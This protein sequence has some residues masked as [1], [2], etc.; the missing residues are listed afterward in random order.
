MATD[1]NRNTRHLNRYLSLAAGVS[2]R[3]ADEMVRNGRV[4]LDGLPVLDPGT[5][6]DPSA[7]EVRLDGRTLVPV[8][9]EDRLD[10]ALPGLSP[11]HLKGGYLLPRF[12]SPTTWSPR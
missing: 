4:T 6:W 2:R 9:E 1:T 10:G 12:T 3:V 8:R 7:Q 11:G 5:L